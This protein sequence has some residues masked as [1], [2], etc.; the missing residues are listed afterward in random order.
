MAKEALR[1]ACREADIETYGAVDYAESNA[2]FGITST[3]GNKQD[4][5]DDLRFQDP[6]EL[7]FLQHVMFYIF[8]PAYNLK[9]IEEDPSRK[10]ATVLVGAAPL[11]A[12]VLVKLLA[13]QDSSSTVEPEHLIRDQV[14]IILSELIPYGKDKFDR[15]VTAVRAFRHDVWKTEAM[16]AKYEELL[17]W[18][19]C[20]DRYVKKFCRNGA[21][22]PFIVKQQKDN[23]ESFKVLKEKL[24]PEGIRTLSY[25]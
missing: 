8:I 21:L 20:L 6:S 11:K 17:D 14:A 5:L 7:V 25:E 15:F 12:P 16:T 1:I 24:N 10:G 19:Y 3:C 2:D 23:P 13:K 18:N 22:D 9:E 4:D